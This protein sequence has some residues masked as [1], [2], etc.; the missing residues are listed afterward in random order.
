MYLLLKIN[1]KEG[2]DDYDH[3]LK[4]DKRRKIDSRQED[5]PSMGDFVI[6]NAEKSI[7]RT[8]KLFV[9]FVVKGMHSLTTIEEPGFRD[10]ISG[11]FAL[12]L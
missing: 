9:N 5:Q 11:I 8:E 1:H 4:E 2:L 6:K 12:S 7:S 10:L 3:E